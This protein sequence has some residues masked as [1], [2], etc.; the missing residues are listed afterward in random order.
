MRKAI[1]VVSGLTIFVAALFA[2]TEQPLDVKPGLWQVE[3]TIHYSGLPPQMQAM[4]DRMTPQQK[5]AMGIDAPHPFKLCR[6]A[7]QLNTSWVQGDNNCKWT[8]VK[9]TASDLEVHGTSCRQGQNEGG[10]TNVDVK[11]HVFDPEHLRGSIHGTETEEGVNATLDGTYTAKWLAASCP[12][13]Q[14]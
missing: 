12:A 1:L 7:K 3:R 9:S 8:V 6:T 4:L 14:K 11:I 2:V 10:A 5:A 13:D